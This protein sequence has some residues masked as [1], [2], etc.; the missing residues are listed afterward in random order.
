MFGVWP[1]LDIERRRAVQPKDV[2]R[3]K[4]KTNKAERSRAHNETETKINLIN[5][6][7]GENWHKQFFIPYLCSFVQKY[8][9]AH[10]RFFFIFL[11]YIVCAFICYSYTYLYFCFV[12][13]VLHA[14]RFSVSLPSNFSVHHFHDR[15]MY[16]MCVYEYFF[17]IWWNADSKKICHI[18]N[19]E[20][21][22]FWSSVR[23]WMKTYSGAVAV[24][25]G[26]YKQHLTGTIVLCVSEKY[27]QI[28]TH[29][30][31]ANVWFAY[32]NWL[33]FGVVF[34]FDIFSRSSMKI[35]AISFPMIS[36]CRYFSLSV[37][38]SKKERCNLLRKCY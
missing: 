38:L 8:C 3:T 27:M 18:L 16:F 14:L 24:A 17:K 11:N 2:D 23:E 33:L 1:A 22:S 26:V 25:N 7:R 9:N 28:D 29:T 12:R 20:S 34:L 10:P 35:Q 31:T 21:L 4:W 6:P 32:A 5:I 15:R 37:F 30:H 13:F 36:S 19:L